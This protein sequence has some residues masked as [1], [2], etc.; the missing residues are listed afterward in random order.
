LLSIAWLRNASPLATGAA[1]TGATFGASVEDMVAR[2]RMLDKRMP[3]KR[4]SGPRISLGEVVDKLIVR[5]TDALRRK[6]IRTTVSDLI[7]MRELHK[8]LTPSPPLAQEVRW[9]DL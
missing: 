8:E 2:K 1:G 3:G 5:C 6:E 7:R 9:V 4:G